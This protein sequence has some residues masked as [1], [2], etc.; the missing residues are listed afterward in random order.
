LGFGLGFAVEIEQ[1]RTMLGTKGWYF[2]GGMASTLFWIDPI[3]QLAG[4]FLTQLM[5]SSTY[6]VRHEI[7]TLTYAAMAE[8]YA[9]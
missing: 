1:P 6:A 9:R 8:S 4:I 3:E 7:R 5:P 2:W